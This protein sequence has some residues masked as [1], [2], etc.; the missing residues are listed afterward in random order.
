MQPQ[1]AN[2]PI[3][4]RRRQYVANLLQARMQVFDRVDEMTRLVA[5][6]ALHSSKACGTRLQVGDPDRIF[7][8][9]PQSQIASELT[10][11]QCISTFMGSKSRQ[12]L[13][14]EIRVLPILIVGQTPHALLN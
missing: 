7:I 11:Q 4:E 14:V 10:T 13:S 9:H 8:T 12:P 6:F 5:P 1:R 2:Q 3:T